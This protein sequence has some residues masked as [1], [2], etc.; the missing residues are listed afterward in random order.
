MPYEYSPNQRGRLA[1]PRGLSNLRTAHIRE[2]TQTFISTAALLPSGETT[3][4]H[5]ESQREEAEIV[6]RDKANQSPHHGGLFR[7]RFRRAAQPVA[8]IRDG[9]DG[10]D[11]CPMCTWEIEDGMC[12]S[13]GYTVHDY[14][15]YDE[16]TDVE[17]ELAADLDARPLRPHPYVD[18][19]SEDDDHGSINSDAQSFGS[20]ELAEVL[21]QDP[22]QHDYD[23]TDSGGNRRGRRQRRL[24][25]HIRRRAGL[26]LPA[27]IHRRRQLTS[28]SV[29]SNYGSEEDSYLSGES[30]T[31]GSSQDF[32]VDDVPIDDDISDNSDDSGHSEATSGL[33]GSGTEQLTHT[34]PSLVSHDGD[35][36]DTTAVNSTFRRSRGRRIATSSPDSSEVDESDSGP[37]SQPLGQ[38][39]QGSRNGGG[40][41]PLHLNPATG[42][43]PIIPIQVDSDS[44]APPVRR[45]RIR[46]TAASFMSD[47]DD[48]NGRGVN[49]PNSRGE[50]SHAGSATAGTHPPP[51]DMP[52]PGRPSAAAPSNRVP[53]LAV[54]GSSPAGASSSRRVRSPGQMVPSGASPSHRTLRGVQMSSDDEDYA[55]RHSGMLERSASRAGPSRSPVD[56]SPRSL[57]RTSEQRR[58]RK[59]QK[60]QDETRRQQQQQG[61]RGGVD[62]PS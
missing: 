42:R 28:I 16:Y 33:H 57:R 36:S 49:I 35:S 51:P 52:R 6:E 60:R 19:F 62:P 31:E 50:S 12:N 58:E 10:V 23:S 3:D 41:S 5:K 21:A 37:S 1:E 59:R 54:I 34:E 47:D 9:P 8:P 20:I 32:M 29:S 15:D 24:M 30:G 27:P 46:R 7:G 25:E 18:F 56:P 44:D 53:S 43:A 39:H 11:R 4:D 17:P 45:R 38:H 55:S 13:C 14:D 40:F 48:D 61:P 26:P 22:G 2:I